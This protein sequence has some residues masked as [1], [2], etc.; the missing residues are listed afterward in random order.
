MHTE[1]KTASFKGAWRLDYNDQK[2]IVNCVCGRELEVF[3]MEEC[4]CVGCG[5]VYR[6]VTD[7]H[8]TFDLDHYEPE[9]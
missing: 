3:S 7:L 4:W 2:A 5:R 1:R 6:L 9:E 8:V